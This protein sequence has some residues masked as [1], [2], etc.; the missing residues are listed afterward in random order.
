MY[1]ITSESNINGLL[2]WLSG[3][4]HHSRRL[5]TPTRLDGTD[6]SM[7]Q[8]DGFS[9]IVVCMVC[10][11]KR[12]MSDPKLF[13]TRRLTRTQKICYNIRATEHKIHW[14]DA[15][16]ECWVLMHWKGIQH[17]HRWRWDRKKETKSVRELKIKKNACI[18]K[19]MSGNSGIN[20]YTTPVTPFCRQFARFASNDTRRIDITV[21]LSQEN[22]LLCLRPM[23]EC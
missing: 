16:A 4:V 15:C 19:N 11:G 7:W 8:N 22:Q 12:E 17:Q 6:C 3:S 5:S 1:C 21:T 9:A 10:F 13:Y 23:R 14:N 2:A 20:M 18:R